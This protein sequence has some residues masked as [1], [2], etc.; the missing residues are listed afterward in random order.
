MEFAENYTLYWNLMESLDAAFLERQGLGSSPKDSWG[1]RFF[2][3]FDQAAA[4][5][6]NRRTDVYMTANALLYRFALSQTAVE[7]G[8][9]IHRKPESFLKTVLML[10]DA[11]HAPQAEA[12][13]TAN[14][15][16]WTA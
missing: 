14:E 10:L 1:A 11:G 5:W 12:K 4:H 16:E 3:A 15:L 7:I 8:P 13:T 9:S 6:T 2:G